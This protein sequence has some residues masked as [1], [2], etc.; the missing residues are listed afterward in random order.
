[1]ICSAAFLIAPQAYLMDGLRRD[2]VAGHGQVQGR[3]R[4]TALGWTV[5]WTWQ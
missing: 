2:A 3:T 1:M 4:G 5:G